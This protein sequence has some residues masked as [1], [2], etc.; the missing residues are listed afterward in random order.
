MGRNARKRIS[1]GNSPLLTSPAQLYQLT[2]AAVL[3]LANSAAGH[4]LGVNGLAVDPYNSI[5]Y[6]IPIRA[7]S[8]R[9]LTVCVAEQL[10]WRQRR[11][12]MRLG[13]APRPAPGSG[14]R[15]L[16]LA[17][18]PR[19]CAARPEAGDNLQAASAGPHSLD[20]RHHPCAEQ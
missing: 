19:R 9:T 15:R 11:R 17:R 8:A 12:N 2:A 18:R 13:H 5:L 4:R 1:Y 10:L 6:V 14:A 16:R 3:P 7:A 20:Q